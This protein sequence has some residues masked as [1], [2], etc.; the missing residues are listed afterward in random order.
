[1]SEQV[2]FNEDQ[3]KKLL[4]DPDVRAFF[5]SQVEGFWVTTIP[6]DVVAE[7]SEWY[8]WSVRVVRKSFG[9]W[10]VDFHGMNYDAEGH[11]EYE[12]IPSSRTEGFIE[13]FR[14]SL[15]VAV[16]LAFKLAETVKQNGLTAEGYTNWYK[17]NHMKV[18]RE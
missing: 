2:V 5:D 11:S 9:R 13:R 14:H 18:E 8:V 3:L 4:S 6:S 12:D 1:M 17:K 7:S 16:P 15:D 10:A